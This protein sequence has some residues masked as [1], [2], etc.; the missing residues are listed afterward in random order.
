MR[1]V[2]RFPGEAPNEYFSEDFWRHADGYAQRVS[3]TFD[4]VLSPSPSSICF[5][6]GSYRLDVGLIV[7]TAGHCVGAGRLPWNSSTRI[8]TFGG[9]WFVALV[10]GKLHH[11]ARDDDTDREGQGTAHSLGAALFTPIT[12]SPSPRLPP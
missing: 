9:W 11:E 5:S 4:F 12:L 1:G 2:R 7:H 10:V 6:Q 3:G 8:L